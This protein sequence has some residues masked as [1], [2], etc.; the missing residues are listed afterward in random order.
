MREATTTE[1]GVRNALE[2]IQ[3]ERRRAYCVS[4]D[5]QTSAP[6][7]NCIEQHVRPTLA[8]SIPSSPQTL[9]EQVNAAMTL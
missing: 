6:A 9:I 3:P 8:T 5:A 1:E 7:L 2:R 4:P